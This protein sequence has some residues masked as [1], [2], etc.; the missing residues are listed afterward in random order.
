LEHGTP[1]LASI[2][3]LSYRDGEGNTVH[4]AIGEFIQ[5]LDNFPMPD[6]SLVYGWNPNTP[7]PISSSRG[8]PYGCN[9]CSVIN[10][11]GR[12][13]RFK[14]VETVL[15]E[16][17]YATSMTRATKF[18]VDDNFAANIE[19]AKA[20]LRGMIERGIKTSWSAQVRTEVAKDPEL[21]RLMADSGC[22]ALFIGFESINPRTLDAYNK[23]QKIADI[24]SCIRAVKNHG[25][26]IHGMFVLGADTDDVD[27]IRDTASFATDLGLD[28][29]QFMMLTPLPGTP[30]FLDM[31]ESGRLLHKDWSKY[32][33]HHA[34]FNP[35][36]MTPS[37]L[38]IETFKAMGRFY[39]WKHI[40][41]YLLRLEFQYVAIGM[42][43]KK[44]VH[45]FLKSSASYLEYISKTS[46]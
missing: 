37:V 46:K 5:D 11:F 16:L 34:V 6:F 10:L 4:N 26:H 21:L 42:F 38:Q 40:L 19:R 43:G 20:I 45:Q 30:L 15:K 31:V 23:K 27:T 39:T 7:Y 44:A 28:S 18:F 8:C 32:D 35:A 12:Q 13:Y 25:I 29:V 41:R 17:K 3:G 33:T 14:S 9:F 24:V 2:K 22:F 36:R 1:E